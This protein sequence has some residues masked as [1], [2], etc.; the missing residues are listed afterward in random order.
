MDTK[1][2]RESLQHFLRCSDIVVELKKIDF[3]QGIDHQIKY[4]SHYNII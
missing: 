3:Y 1:Q 2:K 4:S